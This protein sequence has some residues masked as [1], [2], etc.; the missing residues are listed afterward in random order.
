MGDLG[1][2]TSQLTSSSFKRDVKL[3]FPCRDAA[4]AMDL[5]LLSVARNPDKPTQNKLKSKKKNARVHFS[6][7][8]LHKHRTRNGKGKLSLSYKQWCLIF[9]SS[10][11]YLTR[12]I[13]DLASRLSVNTFL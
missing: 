5:N 1:G 8:F 13:S 11:C 6:Q 4:C 2:L 3:G 7:P 12:V 10:Y 9:Y